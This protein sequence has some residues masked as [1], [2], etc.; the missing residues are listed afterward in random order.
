M[1]AGIGPANTKPELI[2]RKGLHARGWR[3]RL[4]VKG[5]PGKPDLVFPSR[6]AVILV[7]GCFWHGHDC[8]LFRW[9]STR[10]EFWRTKISGNIVRDRKVRE[11]LMTLGWRVLEIWECML[12]GRTRRPVDEVL[13]D[14]VRFLKSDISFASIGTDQ[15]VTID[16]PA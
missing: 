5:L 16:A 11:Q 9:P 7:Q 1:M 15:T 4:H 14:C 10:D 6:K 2:M 12:K 8:H 13:D 3:Y